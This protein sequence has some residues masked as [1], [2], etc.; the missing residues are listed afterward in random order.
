[1]KL[2]VLREIPGIQ[3]H[4][5]GE[6]GCVSS[7]NLDIMESF[8]EGAS[9]KGV[10]NLGWNPVER[11][12]LN[13][14][15]Y[16]RLTRGGIHTVVPT[17][18][19]D[20]P[21]WI[22]VSQHK[23]FLL[24]SRDHK[25]SIRELFHIKRGSRPL[26]RGLCVRDGLIIFGEYWSN[27]SRKAVNIYSIDVSSGR[28]N[29]LH[30]FNENTI[31]HVHAVEQD[32]YGDSLWISTGDINSECMIARF[33][34]KTK[35]L[36]CL[37]QGDQKWRTLSFAFKPEAVYWGTDNHLGENSI[38]RFDRVTGTVEKVA[39]VIGPVYYN[40]CLGTHVIFGTTMEKG[41]GEQDGFG[42]LYAIDL[43]G[44]IQEIW[45]RRKDRWDALL[46]GYGCFEFAEGK[47]PGNRFW[48]TEKGFE[49]GLRSRL[50][51]LEVD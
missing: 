46:F 14:P 48:V 8:D 23:I 37:G 3:V 30:Q 2:N 24:S 5:A 19:S 40:V 33:D 25:A 7:K 44:D 12:L 1:M 29:V 42:R 26:R 28:M 49:G 6:R 22:V 17:G 15:L 16:R 50:F 38:W 51:Q 4:Y 32:P 45:K 27:I 35:E 34:K 9:W 36:A 10:V 21:G 18:E 43:D 31:R 13:F 11:L 20:V 39:Q 47:L 41:E